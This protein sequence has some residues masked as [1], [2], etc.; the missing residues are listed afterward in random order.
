MLQIPSKMYSTGL[1]EL[2]GQQM[3]GTELHFYI[4]A[5]FNIR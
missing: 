4:I 2:A 3:V 5:F 1:V